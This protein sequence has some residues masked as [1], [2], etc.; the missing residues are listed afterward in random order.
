MIEDRC[1]V[2]FSQY[3]NCAGSHSLQIDQDVILPES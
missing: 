2:G 1:L 3:L